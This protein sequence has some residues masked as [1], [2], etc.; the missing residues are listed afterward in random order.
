MARPLRLDYAGAMHH[1]FIRGV[2]RSAVAVDDADYERALQLLERML[3][4]FGL[5]C[6]A[7][8]YLPNHSHLL[9]T[10]ELG[11]LSRAMH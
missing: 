9:V 7:W 2:A 11:K 10:S 4:R 8:C 3:P 1:V 5:R 6:H